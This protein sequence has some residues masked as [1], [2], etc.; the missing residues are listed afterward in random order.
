MTTARCSAG[1]T[2]GTCLADPSRVTST[3]YAIISDVHANIEALGAVLQE[4]DRERVGEI[5]CL[6][7]I[8]GYNASPNECVELIRRRGIR[9]IAGNHDR[10]AVGEPRSLPGKARF[11]VDWTSARLKPDNSGYLRRLPSQ[12]L[13]DGRFFVVHGALHPEPNDELHLSNDARVEASFRELETGRF[14]SRICFFGHTHRPVVYEQGL[15]ATRVKGEEVALRPD[16][17]YLVNPGS[18]GEP[19]DRDVRAAYAL[20][21]AERGLVTFRRVS[22]DWQAARE[23]SRRAGLVREES[24]L[25]R[26]KSRVLEQLDRSRD[27]LEARLIR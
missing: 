19:R 17:H 27:L 15:T 22:Y 21:D 1:A 14:G 16:A 18:V 11:A 12:M 2:P 4:I 24:V 23:R 13:V 8:V 3:R 5:V 9:A 20:F 10:A 26:V 7:D 6:G 25:A